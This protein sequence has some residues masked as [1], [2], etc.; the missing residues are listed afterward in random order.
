MV[1]FLKKLK[2]EGLGEKE[3]RQDGGDEALSSVGRLYVDVYQTNS[4]VVI[5]APIFGAD[6]S[7][8]DVSI[9][10]DNDVIK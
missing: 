7:D 2:G 8:V 1:S 5:Y 9:E 10:G 4:S 3:D 6:I